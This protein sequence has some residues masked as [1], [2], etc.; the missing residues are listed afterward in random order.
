M[1]Q[2]Y[3]SHN[4]IE[5][6]AKKVTAAYKKEMVPEKHLCYTVDP[7][8][9]AGV[10][11]LN[12][13]FQYLSSDGSLLGITAP[14]ES[15][16]TILDADG[17][18]ASYFLDGNTVLIEKKLEQYPKFKGRRNFTIAHEIAHQVIYRAFPDVYGVNCRTLCNYRRSDKPRRK[19][20]D[21]TEWQ[22]DALAAAL[23]LPEDAVKDGMFIFGLGER[24]TVLSKKYSPNKFDAFCRMADFLGVSKTTLSY[25]MERLGL[26]ERNRICEVY[27]TKE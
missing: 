25:R 18:R 23:L 22:A 17:S 27:R 26:L 8:S 20:T 16:V 6:I 24:I 12:V 2:L 15:C 4:D 11:H 7:V 13:D 1:S 5:N 19:I 9:L 3:L 10:L 21:W 14:S